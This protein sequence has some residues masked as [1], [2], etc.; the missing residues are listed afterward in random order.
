MNKAYI[1]SENGYDIYNEADEFYVD[2]CSTASD[3]GND[4][5]LADRKK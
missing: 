5:T 4:I 1:F 3:N 2:L